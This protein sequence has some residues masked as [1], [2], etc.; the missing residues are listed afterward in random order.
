MEVENFYIEKN[1]PELA[2]PESSCIDV[3]SS[4]IFAS[5]CFVVKA[6][7][8]QRLKFRLYFNIMAYFVQE[9]RKGIANFIHIFPTVKNMS[10]VQHQE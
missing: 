6:F 4:V 10:L 8:F 2:S 5:S 7:V 9:C 3:K 1:P